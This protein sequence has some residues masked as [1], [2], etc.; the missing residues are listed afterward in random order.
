MEIDCTRDHSSLR[1]TL[2]QTISTFTPERVTRPDQIP[3]DSALPALST[4]RQLLYH[5]VLLHACHIY[6]ALDDYP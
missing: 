6:Y 1:D 3:L 5:H 4:N 2:L